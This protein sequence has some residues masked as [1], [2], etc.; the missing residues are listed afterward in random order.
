MTEPTA[1]THYVGIAGIGADAAEYRSDDPATAKKLGIFGY[2]RATKLQDVTDGAANTIM[3]AQVPPTHKRPWMAG[4]GSTVEGER[5][6]GSVRPFVSPQPDGKRGTLAVMADGS[7]RFVSEDVKD[8]IFKA[9]CTIKGGESGIILDRDAVPVPRPEGG[10][11]PVPP[12]AGP[13]ADTPQAGASSPVEWKEFVSKEGGFSVVMPGTPTS[14]TQVAKTPI[15]AVTVH[16]FAAEVK[17]QGRAYLVTYNDVPELAG[18]PVDVEKGLDGSRDGILANMP[19]SKLLEEKKISLDGFPGRELTIEVPG[20]GT[21]R[22][23][24]Y[25]VKPRLY[26]VV[27]FGPKDITGLAEADKFFDSFKPLTK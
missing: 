22:W 3:M 5:E 20:K 6:L 15:G 14:G 17:N 2:D 27:A 9:L 23:R 11:E 18:Q 8:D 16:L 25:M 1:A 13:P 21:A 10:P 7:V 19:G 24:V 4:G 26:Q 12:G